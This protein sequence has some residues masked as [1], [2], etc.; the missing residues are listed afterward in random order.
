MKRRIYY[1]DLV[2][3]REASRGS[4]KT[5]QGQRLGRMSFHFRISALPLTKCDIL[6][7]NSKYSVFQF[8]QLENGHDNK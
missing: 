8:P 3:L 6:Y 5:T 7:D 4:M 2:S 1:E